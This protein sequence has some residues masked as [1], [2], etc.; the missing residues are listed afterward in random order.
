MTPL[1][2]ETGDSIGRFF[3]RFHVL[4]LHFPVACL[5]LAVACEIAHYTALTKVHART[6]AR[7]CGTILVTTS[8]ITA[9][10][11][12]GLGLALASHDGHSGELVERH[13]ILGVSVAALA[14]IAAAL[15][16]APL[17][18]WSEA[19]QGTSL[20]L[21]TGLMFLAAHDGGSLVHGETYLSSHAPSSIKSMLEPA[22]SDEPPASVDGLTQ[23]A[24][25][26]TDVE[27]LISEESLVKFDEQALPLLEQYCIRCHGAGKQ[28]GGL[29]FD[30]LHPGMTR[31]SDI[32][33]W[34]RA[35]NALN[36]YEMPPEDARQITESDRLS[37]L[38]WLDTALSEAAESQRAAH[39]TSPMRRLTNVE[40]N[41]TL[42][43]LFG[44][45]ATFT[46][47]LPPDP[48]GHSGY[49]KDSS[50]L[51][52]SPLQLEYYL[53]IA[54]EA[55]DRYVILGEDN[56]DG[57]RFFF[58]EMEEVQPMGFQ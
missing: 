5:V 32:S 22:P 31:N 35:R 33:A 10:I 20:V 29:R 53:E 48:I 34:K 3:G 39:T 24:A 36:A 55:V 56:T 4:V 17:P 14:V 6:V 15:R 16:H 50:L 1:D 45:E 54:R 18:H 46:E 21:A 2:G 28:E 58:K 7:Q 40:Y 27:P 37:L 25:L 42:N 49:S 8:A 12:V 19:I 30:Q 11:T 47:T 51:T 23:N 41:H 57:E 43:E 9:C 52:L 26:H 44:V 38:T 13:M